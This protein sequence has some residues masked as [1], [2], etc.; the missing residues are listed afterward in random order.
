M[1]FHLFLP[2]LLG[3]VQYFGKCLANAILS[4]A[5]LLLTHAVILTSP[6]CG[7]A[8][9]SFLRKRRDGQSPLS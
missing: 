3:D 8:L 7:C 1:N 9:L 4:A 6:R 2:I 5:R